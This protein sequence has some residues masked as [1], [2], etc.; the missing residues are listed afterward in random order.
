MRGIVHAIDED[1]PWRG[2][3]RDQRRIERGNAVVR[4]RERATLQRAQGRVFPCF[5]ARTGQAVAQH[6]IE[7]RLALGV[8]AETGCERVEQ[9]AHAA[10]GATRSFNQA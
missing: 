2:N 5:A 7:H 10:S 1:Q 4:V 3:S 6:G 8:A 9:G